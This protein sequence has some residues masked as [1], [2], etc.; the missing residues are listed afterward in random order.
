[1]KEEPNTA[2]APMAI[3][4]PVRP[5]IAVRAIELS[6]AVATTVKIP[7]KI[8]PMMIGLAF[9]DERRTS[10]IFNK[11]LSTIGVMPVA[12]KRERGAA[13]TMIT[14]RSK[15]AGTFFSRNLTT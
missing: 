8:I 2:N 11:V 10:P 6:G 13:I 3:G 9:A 5:S 14:I 12:I 1:M 4:I 15:P 7:P